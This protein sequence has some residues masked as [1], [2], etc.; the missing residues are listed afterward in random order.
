M[1]ALVKQ[2]KAIAFVLPMAILVQSCRTYNFRSV[3]LEEAAKDGRR[4]KIKTKDKEVWKFKKVIY[5]HGQF[6]GLK[7]KNRKI[8]IHPENI[9]KV[10]LH[11]RTLSII[12]TVVAAFF[13]SILIYLVCCWSIS[14]GAS[15][16]F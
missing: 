6:Y 10:K 1:K 13:G 8:L 7:R 16:T 12:Q 4:V 14:I 5:E 11:N 9:K 2:S 15:I 3:T